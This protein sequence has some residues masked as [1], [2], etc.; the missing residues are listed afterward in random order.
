MHAGASSTDRD[1]LINLACHPEQCEPPL[2][3]GLRAIVRG[4]LLLDDGTVLTLDELADEVGLPRL[5]YLDEMPPLFDT[6][7]LALEPA[8]AQLRSRQPGQPR[9]ARD[10]DR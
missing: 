10:S 1:L 4:D 2:A 9:P 6:R 8:A 3:W 7:C 5:P